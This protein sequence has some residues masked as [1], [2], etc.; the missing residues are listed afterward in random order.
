[1]TA[2][3]RGKNDIL[4]VLW[5]E[6]KN[7]REA[8]CSEFSFNLKTPSYSLSIGSF[9]KNYANHTENSWV[10]VNDH[11]GNIETELYCEQFEL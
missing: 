11:V 3:L 5:K 2:T 7:Y 9:G 4:Y 1:M 10:T 8:A 6:T